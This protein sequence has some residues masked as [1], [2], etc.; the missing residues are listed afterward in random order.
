MAA[1]R[2]VDDLSPVHTSNNVEAT[3]DF[4][5]KNGNNVERVLRSNFVLS[6][7]SNVASTLLPKTA[8]LSK[9]QA[10]K[11]PVASTMLLRHLLVWT[12]LYS[13]LRADCL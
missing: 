1:Y 3:F 6:T 9:Q 7:K 8:T 2:R 13:H 4:V 12:G 10:T 5:A 11:L